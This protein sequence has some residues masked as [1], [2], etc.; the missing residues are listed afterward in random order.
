[1]A[2]CLNSALAPTR[3]RHKVSS[4]SKN[5]KWTQEE[6]EA[7]QKL[8]DSRFSSNWADY[9]AYLPGKTAQQIAERWD[10][11]LNPCLIKGSWTREEDEIIVQ[12]V[13][14]NGVKNWT[15]LAQL[16]PG[17]IG[18]QCRERWRN[19]LDPDVN[20]QPWTPEEDQILIEMHETIG[21]QWVKIAERL[22]GRS[23]NA[24]K[25]RWNSTLKKRLEYEKTGT[26]RPKRGRPS[27]KNKPKSA[28][29]V[30]KPPKL[31][32]TI[33]TIPLAP[34]FN[35]PTM[36]S[37]FNVRSP[38]SL[39]SP[40]LRE[41]AGWSPSGRTDLDNIDYSPQLFSPSLGENKDEMMSLLSPM[42]K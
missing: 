30:P 1:M 3:A 29:D 12:F 4:Q 34:S 16:L 13:K 2:D 20:R 39:F 14:E 31:S 35:T 18:K 17:R 24:V 19:H 32:E 8:V 11:V 5:T 41:M 36:M 42:R 25:N 15:K 33:T 21:N 23:D 40:S 10:K 9:V 6:D 26:P 28:D 22:S 7:L 38:F 27:H 37:P